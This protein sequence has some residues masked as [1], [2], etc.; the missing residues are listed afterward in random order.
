ME[1]TEGQLNDL[2]GADVDKLVL[3]TVNAPYKRDIVASTLAECLIE[4]DPGDWL[5]HVATF[6]S[7]VSARL[8]LAFAASHG[9][10]RIKLAQAYS[11]MKAKT[12]EFNLELEAVLEPMA[13]VA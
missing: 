6:F 10:S 8:I 13:T 12:G 1:S 4:A 3:A 11:A 2:D 9:I 5:V 7:D